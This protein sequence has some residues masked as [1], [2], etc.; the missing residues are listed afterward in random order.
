VHGGAF[1]GGKRSR[2]VVL[3][4]PV[5]PLAGGAPVRLAS[6]PARTYAR[7]QACNLFITAVFYSRDDAYERSFRRGMLMGLIKADQ[8]AAMRQREQSGEVGVF[9]SHPLGCECCRVALQESQTGCRQL[10]DG[11]YLCSDCYFDA[12]DDALEALP[13]LP[14]RVRHRV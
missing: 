4:G 9:F 3:A 11:K 10:S 14:P 12:L 8:Y 6:L 13:I 7:E 2:C 5:A 1:Q